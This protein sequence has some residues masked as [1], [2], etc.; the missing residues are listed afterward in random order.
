MNITPTALPGVLI[1][2]PQVYHDA[3]GFF[4]ETFSAARYR[5]LAGITLPFVQD[6]LSHSHRGVLRGLHFQRQRPQGKLIQVVAGVVFDVTVDIDP[7]SPT[8]GQHLALQLSASNHRQ[9]WVPP[10]YAHGFCVTSDTAT[11]IYKCTDYYDPANEAGVAWNS[12]ELGIAWP[13]MDPIL[14]DKDRRQPDFSTLRRR[15]KE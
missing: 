10:G 14:S 12:P 9:L 13:V 3:R 6:N 7:D 11:L 8:F 5:E 1:I 4:I 2:D 15:N